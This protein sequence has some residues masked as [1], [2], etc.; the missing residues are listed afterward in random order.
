MPCPRL[1][2]RRRLHSRNG[3]SILPNL[4]ASPVSLGLQDRSK[5]MSTTGRNKEEGFVLVT[6]ACILVALL[7]FVALGID[8]GVLYGARTSA[9]EVADAAA[10]AGAFTFITQPTA[11]QP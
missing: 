1:R 2:C 3:F 4:M 7:A 8:V 6:V 9:Q 11:S 10:L 5:A